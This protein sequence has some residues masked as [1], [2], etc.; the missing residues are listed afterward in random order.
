M[1]KHLLPAFAVIGAALCAPAL[2][3]PAA[4]AEWPVRPVKLCVPFAA[5][6][7]PDLVAR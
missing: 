2:R 7:T 3:A 5:G 1:T 6:S 4:A